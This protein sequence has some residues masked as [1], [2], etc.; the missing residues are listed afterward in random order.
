MNFKTKLCKLVADINNGYKHRVIE[1]KH[2]Y[3]KDLEKVLSLLI[4]EGIILGYYVKPNSKFFL[5]YLKK[6]LISEIQ[7]TKLCV[8][9]KVSWPKYIT[10]YE[11]SS[12]VYKDSKTIRIT[13]TNMG[14]LVN[15]S[16]QQRGG[17]L[18]LEI[19]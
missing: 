11:L 13:S 7:T 16:Y 4:K 1:I 19:V 12:K 18:L 3:N 5:I 8:K 14:L 2:T 17:E 9:S 6:N 15:T 10:E